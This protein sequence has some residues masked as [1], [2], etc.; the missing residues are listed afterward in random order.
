MAES[1]Q[2]KSLVGVISAYRTT[3]I[4]PLALPAI[5]NGRTEEL[6]INI[7]EWVKCD[8]KCFDK[9]HSFRIGRA[10]DVLYILL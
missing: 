10:L 2:R 7:E 8:H 6:I 5:H 4:K 1:V 3:S 9:T